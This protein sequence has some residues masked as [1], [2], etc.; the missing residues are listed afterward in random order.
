M[1]LKAIKLTIFWGSLVLSIVL[2]LLHRTPTLGRLSLYLLT[3]VIFT[4]PAAQLFPTINIGKVLL[5]VRRETGQ[6]SAFAAFGH[7]ASQLFPGTSLFTILQFGLA[8]GP[9]GF[10]FWGFWALVLMT[11][12]FLTSNDF[13][14][15]LLKRNWFLLHKLIHPLY[16]FVMIHAGLRKGYFGLIPYVVVLLILY[17]F[18]FL[19]ARGVKFLAPPP[20]QL[21]I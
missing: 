11:I 2:A 13:S 7:V 3:L 14:T 8:S 10:Q 9:K 5:A 4:K 17:T 18:R 20:P 12:L 19:A 15:H 1:P 6:A 16:V 21:M